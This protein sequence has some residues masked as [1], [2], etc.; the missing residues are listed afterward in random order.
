MCTCWTLAGVTSTQQTNWEWTVIGATHSKETGINSQDIGNHGK[1]GSETA[2]LKPCLTSQNSAWLIS[3][4]WTPKFKKKST[5]LDHH[6]FS[7]Q[8]KG[9][10][11]IIPIL[12]IAC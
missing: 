7:F 1:L 6:P 2:P 8:F 11:K 9:I 3:L 4:I 5:S 10:Y 12:R